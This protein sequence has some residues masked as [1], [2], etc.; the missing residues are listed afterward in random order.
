MDEAA[1]APSSSGARAL[2]GRGR[3]TGAGAVRLHECRP[4]ARDAPSC[5]GRCARCPATACAAGPAGPLCP[6]TPAS[7]PCS[8][9]TW[10]ACPHHPALRLLKAGLPECELTV[11][12]GSLGADVARTARWS[13]GGGVPLP[14]SP[15]EA[16][17]RGG[18]HR[19]GLGPWRLLLE[20]AAGLSERG[21]TWPHLPSRLLLGRRPGR[22][23]PGAAAGGD[24]TPD[25]PLPLPH[26]ALPPP[27]GRPRPR[28]PRAHVADLG[29]A[30]A[31]EALSI[32]GRK[33]QGRPTCAPSTSRPPP[34]GPRRA[35]GGPTT[36]TRSGR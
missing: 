11:M 10:G 15:R 18:R 21:S 26:A 29:L 9:T 22:R 4:A 3:A 35:T 20:Q 6:P 33:R 17:P 31:R 12:A 16:G 2:P 30:L 28:C 32:A 23:W 34:S 27:G 24:H 19:G 1:W 7:W 36:W 25:G 13:T 8:R 5:W 14:A